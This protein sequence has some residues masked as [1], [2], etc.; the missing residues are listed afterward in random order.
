MNN[1]IVNDL[2][3]GRFITMAVALVS[4]DGAVELL[5][6]G[7]GPTFHVRAADQ[8]AEAF[9]GNGIP[10]GIAAGERYNPTRHLRLDPG[11]ALVLLTDGFMERPGPGGEQF[12]IDRLAATITRHA[13]RPAAELIAAIDAEA[14]AFAQG[15]PQSDDMTV[16]VLRRA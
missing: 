5:S 16:V 4:P 10:L 11:D 12:G 14:T 1:L 6:A 2:S 15:T 7:H 8:R 3:G 13:S 9:G